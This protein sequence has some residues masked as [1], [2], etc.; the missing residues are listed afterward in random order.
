MIIR[1]VLAILAAAC[2]ASCE[3][4]QSGTSP[5]L[6]STV[7]RDAD[8]HIIGLARTDVTKRHIALGASSISLQ[9]L[10]SATGFP[11]WELVSKGGAVWYRDR[12]GEVEL[13]PGDPLPARARAL[14]PDAQTVEELGLVFEDE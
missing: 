14:F 7:V 11:L 3:T 4:T 13:E 10:S 12:D 2:F 5:V 6:V 8:G 1:T 9:V